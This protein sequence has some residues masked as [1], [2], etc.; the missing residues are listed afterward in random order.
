MDIQMAMN[1]R[2]AIEKIRRL[3]DMIDQV[4]M[5][6]TEEMQY[7]EAKTI[8]LGALWERVKDIAEDVVVIS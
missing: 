5:S 1:Y 8:M 4:S 3:L 2:T 7:E 6:H